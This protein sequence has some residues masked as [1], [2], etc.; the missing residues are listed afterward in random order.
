MW[1]L[2]SFEHVA[3]VLCLRRTWTESMLVCR[4]LCFWQRVS[5]CQTLNALKWAFSKSALGPVR[6][7][8][9]HLSRDSSPLERRANFTAGWRLL[10]LSDEAAGPRTARRADECSLGQRHRP[11]TPSHTYKE[12]YIKTVNSKRGWL[13]WWA[14]YWPLTGSHFSLVSYPAIPWKYTG[15]RSPA[16][17]S[18]AQPPLMQWFSVL[19]LHPPPVPPQGDALQEYAWTSQG[20]FKAGSETW[21]EI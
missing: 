4:S 19:F 17:C 20:K 14:H 16:V 10:S 7:S 6:S 15:L 12:N 9:F 11:P 5:V 21:P 1:V 2:Y 8:S 3:P 18:A 13:C